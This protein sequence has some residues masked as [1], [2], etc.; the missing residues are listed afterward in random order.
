MTLG[1][2]PV[3]LA[4]PARIAVT[5][6]HHYRLVPAAAGAGW[7]ASTAAYL[8]SILDEH[9]REILAYHWHPSLTSQ[10][11][12]AYPHLHIGPGAVDMAL[13]EAAQRSRQ[14]NP[15]RSEFHRLH[16]PT[17]RIALEDV[18]RLGIEQF[19]VRPARADWSCV[20]QRSREQF[21]ATRTWV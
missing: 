19:H 18:V 21:E 12:V 8:Y 11:Q 13:L 3:R 1:V 6:D 20:L 2:L 5:A 10:E 7:R 9:G 16:L 14:H 15:L 4:G 17:R